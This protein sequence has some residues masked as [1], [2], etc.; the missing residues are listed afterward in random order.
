MNQPVKIALLSLFSVVMAA[1]AQ[2]NEM[3]HGDMGGMKMAVEAPVQQVISGKG[4][5]KDIDMTNK[6]IT[7]AHEAIPA[8]GWP[9]MT[10]R[11]TFMT[12]DSSI[13]DLKVGSQV[14][15]SFIQQDNISMLQDIKAN[16]S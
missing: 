1:G 14:N 7:I 11:F 16:Q 3:Q 4:V 12:L 6:K 2:A 10:M 13:N 9:A 15:F 5:V 8:V